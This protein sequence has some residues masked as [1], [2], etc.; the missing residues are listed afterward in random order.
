VH[1]QSKNFDLEQ[2]VCSLAALIA[3]TAGVFFSGTIG[4]G[5]PF[6]V[7]L[8]AGVIGFVLAYVSRR[9]AAITV[10]LGLV[11]LFL[12]YKTMDGYSLENKIALLIQ[13]SQF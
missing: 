12:S 6:L 8:I 5:N 4:L 7:G 9:A 2:A 1:K 3:G 11:I 10:G 13:Q